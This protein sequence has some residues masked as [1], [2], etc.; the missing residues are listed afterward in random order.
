MRTTTLAIILGLACALGCE[1]KAKTDTAPAE[2]GH[3]EVNA[4]GV[5]VNVDREKG[6]DV[7]TPAVDVEA[8][9]EGDADVK[10]DG[11]EPK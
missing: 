6:V 4:P 3:I 10:V 2:G 9:P 1:K 5:D 8:T 7:K 11:D